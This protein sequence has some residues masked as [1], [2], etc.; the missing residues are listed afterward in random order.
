MD[1]IDE[2]HILLANQY[3]SDY[4]ARIYKTGRKENAIPSVITQNISDVIKNE[5]GCKIL[6][7]SEFA[8]ILK[9]KLL[10]YLLYAKS[11]ILVKK[12]LNTL[13]IHL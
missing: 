10:I 5:N 6:S 1:F 7:N 9:Q 12:N 8:M 4:I 3:S 2:F 13:L 11:L